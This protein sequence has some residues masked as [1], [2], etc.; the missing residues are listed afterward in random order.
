MK[1]I[2]VLLLVAAILLIAAYGAGYWPQRERLGALEGERSQLQQRADAA[3]AKV[4]AGQLLG[5]LLTLEETVQQMNYG[6][7]RG[8]SSPFFNRVQA[9]AART[10]DPALK[11][12]LSTIQQLRD[13]VTVGLTQGDPFALN[14]LRQAE[15]R[16]RAALGYP[17]PAATVAPLPTPTPLPGV[18]GAMPPI[19]VTPSPAGPSPTTAPTIVPTA[20]PTTAPPG[21]PLGLPTPTPAP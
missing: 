14:H 15:H 18:P 3:E 21:N 7:A 9:E 16:L 1:K 20:A 5:E 8:L 6:Q 10:T 4:R 17:A 12:A 19:G 11:Q 2:F 13:P